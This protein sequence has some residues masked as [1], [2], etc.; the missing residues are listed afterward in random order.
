[1]TVRCWKGCTAIVVKSYAGNEGKVVQ[2]VEYLGLVDWPADPQLPTWRIDKF[3]PLGHGGMGDTICDFQLCP[4]T[5]AV[6][7]E[8]EETAEA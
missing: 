5:P 7:A 4:I 6:T 2:C 1:M 3:L 8:V